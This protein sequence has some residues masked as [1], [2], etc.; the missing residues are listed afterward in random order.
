MLTLAINTSTKICSVALYDDE[1]GVLAEISLFV[2]KNHSNILM[3]L[4]DQ[5][6]KNSSLDIK[7]VDR[8]AVSLGPGSFTGV[9]IAL[10]VAKGFA[11]ALNKPLFAVSELD[12][13]IHSCNNLFDD[14]KNIIPLIDAR[15]ERVF[16]KFNDTYADGN[17]NDLLTQL[18]KSKKYI[19][20]GDG[21]TNYK[22][23]ISKTL[24]NNL[25]IVSKA[26]MLSRASLIA[27]LSLDKQ[28]ENIYTLEP[29]YISKS[30]AEKS[31]N[32]LQ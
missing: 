15:K 27:E 16:Y 19:F 12:V 18:D 14:K 4:I 3:T 10:S 9:R 26:K 28:E 23:L 8:F 29:Q 7:D 24:N 5:L 17:L 11:L 32:A 13:L 31:K 25:L 1:K 30:Q 6:F 2:T 22:E 20:V 21:A